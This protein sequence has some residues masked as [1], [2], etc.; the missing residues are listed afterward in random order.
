M[1]TTKSPRGSNVVIDEIPSD[2]S[3]PLRRCRKEAS[4]AGSSTCKKKLLIRWIETD[5]DK[6]ISNVQGDDQAQMNVDT[7]VELGQVYTN[8]RMGHTYSNVDT[9]AGSGQAYIEHGFDV[10]ENFEP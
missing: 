9:G 7:R 4:K 3:P 2:V 1:Y 6:T 8:A 10:N 5:G